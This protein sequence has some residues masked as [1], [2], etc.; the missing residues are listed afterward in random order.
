[1]NIQCHTIG[2]GEETGPVGLTEETLVKRDEWAVALSDAARATN[3]IVGLEIAI[4]KKS[5]L[6][7]FH[8]F[9]ERTSF[10]MPTARQ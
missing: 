9:S 6:R 4:L 10:A 3:F 5:V 7:N 2:V 8:D 1:M